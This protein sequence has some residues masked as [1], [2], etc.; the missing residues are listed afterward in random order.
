[1]FTINGLPL[2]RR[3]ATEK[4]EGK[5]MMVDVQQKVLTVKKGN[6]NEA[7]GLEP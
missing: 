1:M 6:P 4:M 5:K 7:L 2:Y 3:E